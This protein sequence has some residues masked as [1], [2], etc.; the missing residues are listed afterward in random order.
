MT[1]RVPTN[2]HG[3]N[4]LVRADIE[5]S[6]GW[7]F[8]G[9]RASEDQRFGYEVWRKIGSVFGWHGGLLEE[10]PPFTVSDWISQR[11]RWLIGNIANA[12]VVKLPWR[13]KVNS[14]F[15]S[16]AF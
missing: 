10:Q 12:R 13:K 7:D 15:D 9:I 3:S 2:M 16:Y 1:G 11:R 6:V 14:F 8:K 4:L 5:D